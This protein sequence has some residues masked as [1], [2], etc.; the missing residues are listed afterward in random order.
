MY[1]IVRLSETFR[2]DQR[3]EEV[4]QNAQGNGS[5]DDVFHGSNPI[6]GVGVA[7][8]DDKEADDCRDVNEIHRPSPF[9]Q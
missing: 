2:P 7:D 6:E 4:N 1:C 9:A 3:P 8:A 5:H